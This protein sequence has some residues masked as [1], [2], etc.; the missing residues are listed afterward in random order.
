MT[1]IGSGA[2]SWIS[3]IGDQLAA[4]DT[5]RGKLRGFGVTVGLVLAVLSL[6]YRK[7]GGPVP[8]GLGTVGI[9]LVLAGLTFPQILLGA[10]RIWMG[11]ALAL[12][13]IVSRIILTILFYLV[14]T[15]VSL[16]ARLAGKEFLDVRWN[17]KR[18][19]Y[20]IDRDTTKTVDHEEMY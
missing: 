15:P 19:S 9:V 6:I 13:W 4:L 11:F 14:M 2:M 3:D 12:G 7:G 17:R 18:N 1:K 16:I 10:Y 20:W 5:S 8:I